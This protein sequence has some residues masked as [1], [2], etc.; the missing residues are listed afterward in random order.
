MR[1]LFTLLTLSATLVLP[2]AGCAGG[3]SPEESSD[4]GVSIDFLSRLG[5]LVAAALAR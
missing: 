1:R 4:P 3:S 5:E 2:L